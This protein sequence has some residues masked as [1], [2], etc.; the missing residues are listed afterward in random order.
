MVGPSATGSLKGTPSSITSAPALA[1]ASTIFSLAASE[2][3][4]AVTYATSPISPASASARKRRAIRPAGC[5][6]TALCDVAKF[7]DIARENIHI[8]IAAPRKIQDH[9]LVLFHP[10]RAANQFRQGMRRFQRRNNS[11]QSRERARGFHGFAIAH[12]AIFRAALVREPGVF[13]TDTRIIQSRGN[14][15]RRRNLPV[16]RLQNVGVSSV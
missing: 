9:Q 7:S 3:S 6:A 10:R 8:L 14:R 1:A 5:T 2:G 16:R 4:P 13:R 15:V 11:F 12:R